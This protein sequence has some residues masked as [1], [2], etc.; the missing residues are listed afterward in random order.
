MTKASERLSYID[1]V[2]SFS[3]IFLVIGHTLGYSEQAKSIYKMIYSFVVPLFF[4]VSGYVESMRK[5]F[6]TFV[7]SRFYR[8]MIPY[9]IWGVVFLIPYAIFNRSVT[10][11]LDIKSTSEIGILVKNI[12]YGVGKDG[13][14]KQNSSLWFLPA[15]FTIETV[16]ALIIPFV[17]SKGKYAEVVACLLTFAIG[18]CA[19]TLL[20]KTSIVLPW[21]GNTFFVAGPFFYMGYLMRQHGSVRS[22]MENKNRWIFFVVCIVLWAWSANTNELLAFMSYSYGN[23][24][25]GYVSSACMLTVLTCLSY[26]IKRQNVLE[27]IGKNT[28][29]IMLFHKLIV[30]VFQTRAG[31]ITEFLKY[32]HAAVEVFL[33]II[34]TAI[35]IGG[36]LIITAILERICPISIGKSRMCK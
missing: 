1:I 3:I 29:G 27:Y 2:R 15:L 5:P 14:L 19:N 7:K 30:L 31:A 4:F 6:F 12:L 35:A 34:I 8:I 11:S 10:E 20:Q 9:F 24:L 21:G 26:R 28:L 13:A 25:K 32:G 17:R 16:Y 33:A 22:I 18:H 23:L 36:S